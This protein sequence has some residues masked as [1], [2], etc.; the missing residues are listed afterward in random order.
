MHMEALL[1]TTCRKDTTDMY[2]PDATRKL[3]TNNKGINHITVQNNNAFQA[4]QL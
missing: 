1:I 4:R 3:R 2:I